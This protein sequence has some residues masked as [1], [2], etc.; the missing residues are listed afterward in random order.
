MRARS[1]R[2]TL[3]CASSIINIS[4][5]CRVRKCQGNSSIPVP[6]S[7]AALAYTLLDL[8]SFSGPTWYVGTLVSQLETE[9]H[10]GL[11]MKILQGINASRGH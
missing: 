2:N 7:I 10:A 6:M 9:R 11:V 1:E 8:L 4:T 5:F 3:L